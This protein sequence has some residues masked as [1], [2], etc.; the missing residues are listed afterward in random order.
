MATIVF[1]ESALTCGTG[2]QRV[3][4]GADLGILLDFDPKMIHI[5]KHDHSIPRR[6][7]KRDS[8]PTPGEQDMRGFSAT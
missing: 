5:P 2:R 6:S 7:Q 3:D 1:G 8:F 4:R